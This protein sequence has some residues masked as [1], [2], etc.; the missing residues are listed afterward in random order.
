MNYVDD[1]DHKVF[2][3]YLLVPVPV[4]ARCG[5]FADR[6]DDGEGWIPVRRPLLFDVV[7]YETKDVAPKPDGFERNTNIGGA[8]TKRDQPLTENAL[9]LPIS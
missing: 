8:L 7:D 3:G 9:G 6:L 2:N 1:R 4:C 5:S